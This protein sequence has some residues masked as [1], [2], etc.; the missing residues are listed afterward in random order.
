MYGIRGIVIPPFFT[1]YSK[2]CMFQNELSAFFLKITTNF[3]KE[4]IQIKANYYIE[5]KNEK[6]GVLCIVYIKNISF[7][8]CHQKIIH[9]L[10]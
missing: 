3:K 1:C 8:Q 7:T 9:V 6:G 10:K 5:D 4:L 2:E